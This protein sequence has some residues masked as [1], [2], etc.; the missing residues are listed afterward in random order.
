MVNESFTPPSSKPGHRHM[1]SDNTEEHDN[2]VKRDD[3]HE[4]DDE[5]ALPRPDY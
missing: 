4:Q 1:D 3:G 5:N 2:H